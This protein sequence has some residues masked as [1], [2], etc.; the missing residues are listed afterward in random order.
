MK[1]L[2]LALFVASMFITSP[3]SAT[4]LEGDFLRVGVDGSGGLI[5]AGFTVGIDYDE[6]GTGTWTSYD[7]LKP[8]TPFQFNSIGVAGSWVAAGYYNGNNFS[9]TTNE[10]SSGT[11]LSTLTTGSYLGLDYSQSI[12]FDQTS[13]VIHFTI[14]LTNSTM[15][16]L[17]DIV[18]ATGFDPDQDVYAG[19]GYETTNTI[20]SDRVVA[21]APVTGWGTAIVGDGVMT[22]SSG[23]NQNPYELSSTS[24]DD[25]DGDY[26]INMGWALGE[27]GAN[28]MATINFDYALGTDTTGQTDPNP[29]PEPAT[30]ML[31]GIGL[32]SLV[33]VSRRKK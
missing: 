4:I 25:G 7:V 20:Q 24:V 33:G 14:N 30:M 29:I 31:F 12:F 22:V 15:T 26:T 18:F 13:G 6:T 19:G 11:T 2:L 16:T 8:G 32:L 17:E 27:L 28:Q 23:W 5:D 3:A 10:T 9:A 1:K 21:Y